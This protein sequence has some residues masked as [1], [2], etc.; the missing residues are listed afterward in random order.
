[1]S[2]VSEGEVLVMFVTENGEDSAKNVF[3]TAKIY[4]IYE[5]GK[6]S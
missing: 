1:M 4:I 3:R 2:V 6:K 5:G